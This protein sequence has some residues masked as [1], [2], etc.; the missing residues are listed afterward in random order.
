MRVLLQGRMY[1]VFQMID[2]R[3]PMLP[4][5]LMRYV[6]QVFSCY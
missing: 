1:N 2:K 3:E 6:F 5:S 4:T